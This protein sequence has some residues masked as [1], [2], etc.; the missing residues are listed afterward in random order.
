MASLRAD[1]TGRDETTEERDDRNCRVGRLWRPVVRPAS[2][3]PLRPMT[4]SGLVA[5]GH[6][7]PRFGAAGDVKPGRPTAFHGPD[8]MLPCTKRLPPVR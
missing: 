4:A 3:I 6:A 2:R 5:D 7:L 8:G 1:D